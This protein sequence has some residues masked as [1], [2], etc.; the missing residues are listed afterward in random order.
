MVFRRDNKVESFQRQI[1]ALRQQ[2]GNEDEIDADALPGEP[3]RYANESSS[4]AYGFSDIAASPPTPA[5]GS[6]LAQPVPPEMPSI[7][8]IS[9]NSTV[10]ARDTTWKGEIDSQGTV[11]VNGRFEGAIRAKETVY[12]ASDADVDASINADSV[13]VAGLVKGTIRCLARF[14]VLPAGRVNGDVYAPALIVHEGAT[15]NGQFRM[16]ATA[17]SPAQS[18]PSPVVQRRANRGTA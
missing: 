17:E 5:Q 12:V 9:T 18:S 11:H 13:I 16:S 4:G 14:E 15:I 2:L 8:A 1:S 3:E 7:P 10:I 6:A